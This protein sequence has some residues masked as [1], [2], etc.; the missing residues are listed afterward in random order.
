MKTFIIF[1]FNFLLIFSLPAQVTTYGTDA[2][3]LG[4]GSSFFGHRAGNNNSAVGRHNTVIGY[5]AGYNNVNSLNGTYVGSSAGLNHTTGNNNTFIGMQSGSRD[6]SG[7]NNTFLG[8]RSGYENTTGSNNT[9]LGTYTGRFNTTG[10]GNL[11]V[12]YTAGYNAL[13]AN[14]NTMLGF[15][16]GYSMTDGGSNVFLGKRSGYSKTSGVNNV[17]LGS[18]AGEN[19]LT[20]NGNV[21][22]GNRAGSNQSGSNMLFIDNSNTDT[23]LIF[24]NF[25]ANQI[26]INTTFIPSDYTFAVD[27]KIIAEEVRV[28]LSENWPDYVFQPS[29]DLMPLP[30][31]KKYITKHNHL[32]DVP[33][34]AEIEEAGGTDVGAMNILLL[35]K[36]EELTL[37]VI[38]LQEEIE[39]L[40]QQ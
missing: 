21:F 38:Q 23:P 6:V 32:P 3:T 11:F 20:G 13:A 33:S 18:N 2:G 14:Y 9:F 40:K 27:G 15:Q 17:F 5:N 16:S 34:A 12:G 35:K 37:H 1:L 29:Y 19:N 24:G 28:R 7:A 8:M 26:G 39:T 30:E 36:V 10:I 31:L 25:S 4:V 22:I